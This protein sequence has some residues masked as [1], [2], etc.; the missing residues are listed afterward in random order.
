LQSKLGSGVRAAFYCDEIHATRVVEIGCPESD[1]QDERRVLSR[2]EQQTET[3]VLVSADHFSCEL[4]SDRL[5]GTQGT[6]QAHELGGSGSLVLRHALANSLLRL[7]RA[8]PIVDGLPHDRGVEIVRSGVA[9]AEH[10][11]AEL[12]LRQEQDQRAT[13]RVA[14]GTRH[15][16]MIVVCPQVPAETIAVAVHSQKVAILF[17]D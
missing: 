9:D 2:Q 14:A 17:G 10:R 7:R 4:V 12:L 16:P 15:E 1:T 6:R 8:D 3:F 13:A 5:R 11:D